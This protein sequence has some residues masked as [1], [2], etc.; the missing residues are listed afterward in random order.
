[1]RLSLSADA[2][3]PQTRRLHLTAGR[4][5]SHAR[6]DTG[7]TDLA[8][9]AALERFYRECGIP[10]AVERAFAAPSPASPHGSGVSF[11]LGRLLPGPLRRELRKKAVQSG[12]FYRVE[13]EFSCPDCVHVD[14]LPRPRLREGDAGVFVFYL[15][16]LLRQ[17]EV[18]SDVCTGVFGEPTRR[19]VLR[20]QTAESL[21][22]SGIAD[23]ALWY[24][25]LRR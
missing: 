8:A 13:P 14:C 9:L 20:L 5:F 18:Y 16:A 21:P 24:A 19:A 6:T 15:Q 4:F 17:R 23:E 11:D 10:F 2:P 25:I 22:H 7:W 12:L 1:M 3:L